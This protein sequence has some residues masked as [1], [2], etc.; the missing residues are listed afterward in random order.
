MKILY[1]HRVGSKDGQSVH[2]DEIVAALRGLGHVVIVAGP[3]AMQR[4][5]FGSDAGAIAFLKK[6]VPSFIYELLELAYSL[7]AFWRLCWIYWRERPDV[8]YE[9]Y[10]LY[11]LAGVW[12]KRLTGIPMLLEVNA[13]LVHERSMGIPV[14]RFSQ[15]PASI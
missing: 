5:E 10:N 12:L 1:H 2:I 7:R 13:P 4:A 6:A 3:E 11:M 14:R 8:L 9:R 15:T